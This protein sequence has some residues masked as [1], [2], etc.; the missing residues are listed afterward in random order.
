MVQIQENVSLAPYTTFH[1]GG[2]ADYFVVVTT[3]D[4]LREAVQWAKDP[5][6]P[7][8][9]GPST[10]GVG[11][12]PYFILGTGA[13]ILVSD[14]GY[15]GL[16][17]KNEAKAFQISHPRGVNKSGNTLTSGVGSNQEIFLTAESGATIAD[18]IEFSKKQE[19]SGLEN[20]AGIVSTVGGALWQNLHFLNSGRSKTVYIADI[21]EGASILRENGSIEEVDKAYFQFGYDQSILHTNKDIVLS[22]TFRLTPMPQEE[23]QKTIDA[24]LE[25]R[26]KKHPKNAPHCTAGS[27]FKKIEQYGAGRLIEKVG[28]KGKVIGGAQISEVHA[29]FIINLGSATAQN[30]LDL[31]HLVQQTV[32]DQLHLDLEPEIS[33][34][35]EF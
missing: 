35:G 21:L 4:E 14:K 24:N 22:A 19:L 2:P 26:A 18:L 13:N 11:A 5:H 23:I 8:V 10:P 9:F 17:I 16:V 1:I 27:I 25:W 6:T 30:V 12:L 28:L 20:Y 33:F 29:N 7:G 3:L 15:R 31:I 34:I 32:K